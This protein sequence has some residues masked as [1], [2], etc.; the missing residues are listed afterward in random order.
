MREIKFR[1]KRKSDGKWLYGSLLISC[2]ND[3]KNSKYYIT[4]FLGNY[5]FEYEVIPETIGQYTGL[6]EYK[7]VETYDGDI[8]KRLDESIYKVIFKKGIYI[9][10]LATVKNCLLKD[11]YPL[12]HQIISISE[13]IGDIYSNPELLTQVK[14]ER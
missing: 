2:F 6:K 7:G 5:T 3:N 11:K 10:E 1:G 14:E 4:S 13:V 9:G 8:L 12:L